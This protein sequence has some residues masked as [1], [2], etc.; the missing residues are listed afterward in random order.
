MK[1]IVLPALLLVSS[2]VSALA[3]TDAEI[4]PTALVGKTLTFTIVNGNSPFATTGTWSGAFA[5][6]G[7][8]FTAT[9]I[10]GDFVNIS[11]T[12]TS[13]LDGG[14][15]VTSLAKIVEGQA[16]AKL[17]LYTVSGVGHYEVS[18]PNLF[19]AGQN[20]TF[21]FGTPVVTGPEIDVKLGT[22]A[23]TDAVGN[24]SFGTVK[25]KKASKPQIVTIKNTGTTKLTG[26]A[27]SKSGKN[28]SDFF[29]TKLPKKS[30][31]PGASMTFKTTFKPKAKGTKN[32]VIKIKSSDKNES[33][34][35]INVTGVATK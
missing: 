30:L 12:F 25:A 1:S 26:L 6:S 5:A 18:I 14:Y 2:I 16:P 34:F 27:V 21:V 33:P 24:N 13:A 28:A 7:N 35:D 29:I 9:R 19:G 11:T 8:A 32:A 15:S 22:A 3:I 17:T 31:A 4:T 23:L 10:T 20:G